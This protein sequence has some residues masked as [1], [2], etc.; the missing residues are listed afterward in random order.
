VALAVTEAAEVEDAVVSTE[1]EE[2]VDVEEVV[3]AAAEEEAEA[4]LLEQRAVK[5][6]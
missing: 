4:E 3:T 6:S 2:E 5:K 1:V